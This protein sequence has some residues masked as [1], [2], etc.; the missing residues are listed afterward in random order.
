MKRFLIFSLFFF[1]VMAGCGRS[2]GGGAP[3]QTAPRIN[4]VYFHKDI[5]ADPIL[6]PL[7]IGESVYGV[8][9]TTDPDLDM[10][11]I[12]I[13]EYW[14]HDASLPYYGPTIIPLGSQPDAHMA[15]IINFV[16][17]GP[18]GNWRIEFQVEDAQAN[19]SNIFTVYLSVH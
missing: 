10:T 6:R 12:L 8:I 17:R 14:P 13:T 18:I 2:G 4:S 15:I 7:V 19:E 3:A 5:Y 16:V 1:L 11:N 9:E